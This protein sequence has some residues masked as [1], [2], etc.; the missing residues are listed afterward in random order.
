M[1]NILQVDKEENAFQRH[2]CRG[3]Q[4]LPRDLQ[5]APHDQSR[6]TAQPEGVSES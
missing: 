4:D 1:K 2:G 5:V 3:Q 6:E